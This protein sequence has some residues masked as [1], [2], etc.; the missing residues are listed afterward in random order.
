MQKCAFDRREDTSSRLRK[1][2]ECSV[3]RYEGQDNYPFSGDA[4][5]ENALVEREQ[6]RERERGRKEKKKRERYLLCVPSH[7]PLKRSNEEK[8]TKEVKVV[9][10]FKR[11]RERIFLGNSS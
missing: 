9:F 6:V 8:C 4:L 3:R 11:S 10:S 7:S 1:I 5:L 2:D